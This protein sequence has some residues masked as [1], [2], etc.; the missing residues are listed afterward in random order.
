MV[1]II[2]NSFCR[3]HALLVA[4][5]PLFYAFNTRGGGGGGEISKI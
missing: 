1:I 3:A 5:M 4:R 2:I